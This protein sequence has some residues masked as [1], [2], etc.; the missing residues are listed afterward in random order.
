M[1][2]RK[3]NIWR[4]NSSKLILS[5]AILL[6]FSLSL[7][8]ARPFLKTGYFP[9]HD[10][11]WAVVRLGAMHRA[12]LAG[13]FPVRWAG[14]L[15]FSYGYPLFLFTY[16]LPYYLGEIFNLL[17]F[18]LVGS[19][20]ILFVLSVLFSGLAMFFL[21][22][23]VFGKTGGLIAAIFYLYAPFRLVNLYVR[24]SLGES[25]AFVLYPLLFLSLVKFKKNPGLWLPLGAI[26][27]GALL[28]THNVSALLIT[29]F[30]VIF[31]FLFAPRRSLLIFILGVGL[32]FFFLF[33]AL[34]EKS[35]IALSQIP[36]VDKS[37]HFVSLWQLIVPRWGYGSPGSPDAF[38]FQLG[39]VHFLGLAG[40]MI[41][42]LKRL[43]D[44]KK[45]L[46]FSVFA[47]SFASLVVLIFSML[48]FSGLFWQL[49][50]FKEVDFPWRALG[51]GSFFLALS[52]GF[53]G[54]KRYTTI[55][56]VVL[57]VLAVIINFQYAKPVGFID[58]PDD[59]YLTN[60]ATTTSADELMPIW[61]KE[62]PTERAKEKVEILSGEGIISNLTFN[63]KT[64]S[65]NVEA[66]T[67]LEVQVNTI[68]FPGWRVM[69]DAKNSP[70]QYEN[71][72]GVMRL[73][74]EPGKHRV[75]AEFG[76]TPIRFLTDIISLTSLVLV[77]GLL[78]RRKKIK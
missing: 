44:K 1:L 66:E 34:A 77:G 2:M 8:I 37:R 64:V 45:E 31:A 32:S 53:L 75:V 71:E 17:G 57:A 14:N 7:L 42:W 18:G 29:L 78:I 35:K 51:L 23:E 48:P 54:T 56:A 22:K 76:E 55:A 13:H 73:R 47:F 24:G 67:E 68:Y 58:Y 9:T 33:P 50:L 16:P 20:K 72:K 52:L 43:K 69:V 38:S 36:L 28:L 12:F 10:G 61:V 30:L 4:K 15:N 62:K 59:Y 5:A 49:P 6:I 74:I 40:A 25:L 46:C 63:S 3:L 39:W 11:E 70:L 60:E 26:F 41:F 21:A 27:Y 19:I 65:F